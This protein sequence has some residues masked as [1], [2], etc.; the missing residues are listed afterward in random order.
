MPQTRDI[1]YFDVCLVYLVALF[2]QLPVITFSVLVANPKKC[3]DSV[4]ESGVCGCV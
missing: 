2:D 1:L 3:K 4:V